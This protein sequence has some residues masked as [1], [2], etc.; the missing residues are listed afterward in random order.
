M[1]VSVKKEICLFVKGFFVFC[2]KHLEMLMLY[3]NLQLQLKS[4]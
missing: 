1:K 4:E 3:I 2:R